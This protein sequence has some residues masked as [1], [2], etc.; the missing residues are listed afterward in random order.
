MGR[1]KQEDLGH[2]A[3]GPK[4]QENHKELKK[5]HGKCE[6]DEEDVEAGSIVAKAVIRAHDGRQIASFDQ[7][8]TRSE[9]GDADDDRHKNAGELGLLT[10]EQNPADQ[11]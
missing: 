6:K 2:P 3:L 1:R 11:R 8:D 5:K 7:H 4:S 9:E 10:N